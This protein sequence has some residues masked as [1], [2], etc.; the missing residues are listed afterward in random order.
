M[1]TSPEISRK[2][3]PLSNLNP[4]QLEAV[5]HTEGPLL[6]LAG[7][8]TGK[9][10]VITH[11]IAHLVQER[12]AAPRNILAVTFTNKAAEE[13]RHRVQAL[14]GLGQNEI[15]IST[16]HSACLR[17]LRKS[18]PPGQN[19]FVIYDDNDT[20]TLIRRCLEELKFE[21]RA[22]TPRA[23]SSR[24]AGAKNDLVSAEAYGAR[25][26]DFFD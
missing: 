16:F 4:Q 9:T 23:V 15:W 22:F 12:I 14:L 6:I 5:R 10:R 26:E 13:M 24:I 11:R 1:S 8:G 25:T 3:L 20:M 18:L 7:A 2:V 19:Q 21:D 17:I